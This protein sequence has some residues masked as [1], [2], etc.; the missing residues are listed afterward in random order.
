MTRP[1]AK[2]KQRAAGRMEDVEALK[3]YDEGVTK[4]VVKTEV[5]KKPRRQVATSEVVG[6][7]ADE[8]QAIYQEAGLELDE[9]NARDK[10]LTLWRDLSVNRGVTA[11]D[12]AV[13]HVLCEEHSE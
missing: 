13:P 7:M 10:A 12:Q 1:V 11:R 8:I 9:M 3:K 6:I 4:K 5:E 2:A